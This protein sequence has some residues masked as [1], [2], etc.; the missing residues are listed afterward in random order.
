MSGRATLTIVMSIALMNIA[1]HTTS[2]PCCALRAA[3]RPRTA[4]GE[5]GGEL[6]QRTVTCDPL[7]RMA[8]SEATIVDAGGRELRVPAPTG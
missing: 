6:D 8:A 5:G 7:H 2:R 1:P 3:R 4:G